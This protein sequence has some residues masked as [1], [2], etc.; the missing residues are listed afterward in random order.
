[1]RQ[2]D[3]LLP[4]ADGADLAELHGL[5]GELLE[6]EDTP[7]GVRVSVRLPAAA[8]ARFERFA[9]DRDGHAARGA[10]AGPRRPGPDDDAGAANGTGRR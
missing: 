9:I 3:L 2:V 4:Y 5:A 10:D 7:D 6:R 1:M 8:A